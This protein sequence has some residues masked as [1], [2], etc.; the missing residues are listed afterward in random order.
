MGYYTVVKVMAKGKPTKAYVKCGGSSF[1]GYTD[2]TTGKFSFETSS[3]STYS[4][5]VEKSGYV[6]ERSEI[7]GGSV[8]TVALQPE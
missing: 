6:T 2:E 4:L 5:V 8:T 7:K 1:C 3:T